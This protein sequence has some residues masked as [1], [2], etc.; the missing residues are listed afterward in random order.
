MKRRIYYTWT[1]GV[2][3]TFLVKQTRG[4][5]LAQRVTVKIGRR[6]K[7]HNVGRVDRADR[8]PEQREDK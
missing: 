3:R 8:K 1:H 7:H 5:Y 6:W 4:G 2:Q